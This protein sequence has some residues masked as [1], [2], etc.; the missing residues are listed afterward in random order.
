MTAN[1]IKQVA[2]SHFAKNG[3]DGTS[4]AQIANEVGIKKQSIATYFQKKEDLYLAIFNELVQDYINW[5][6]SMQNEISSEPV[7]KKLQYILYQS[8]QYKVNNPERTAFYKRAVHFPPSFLEK[9]VRNE[10][11][12]MEKQSSALYREVF[13]EGIRT[14]VIKNQD[15]ENLL[16]AFYC[17]IDGISI[18]MFFYDRDEFHKR[19]SCIWKI[20][21]DGIKQI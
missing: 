10:F 21:W 12:K 17:L 18:Q 2:L 6:K 13:E 14:N 7:E 9:K 3:Y 8:Y 11:N 5:M 15:T 19:L 16:A 20:F 4:L 1:K